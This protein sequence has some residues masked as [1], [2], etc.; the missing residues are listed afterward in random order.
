MGGSADPKMSGVCTMNGPE[1]VCKLTELASSFFIGLQKN[2]RPC[3]VFTGLAYKLLKY[4]FRNQQR[5]RMDFLKGNFLLVLSTT[6]K[7]SDIGV[8]F[9]GGGM[10]CMGRRGPQVRCIKCL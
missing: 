9:W 4:L 7:F 8:F 6:F 3:K 1:R 5:T 10:T 2:S